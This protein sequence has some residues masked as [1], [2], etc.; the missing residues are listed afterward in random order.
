MIPPPSPP[1]LSDFVTEEDIGLVS[2]S[3]GSSWAELGQILGFSQA[4]LERL[5][6]S[7]HRRAGE[8]MLRKWRTVHP[9]NATF[10]ALL[11]ALEIIQRRD[12][13]DGLLAVRMAGDGISI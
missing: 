12:I 9:Q 10:F 8:E 11:H 1:P 6:A 2:R 3:L 4:E 5:S 7:A 13:A